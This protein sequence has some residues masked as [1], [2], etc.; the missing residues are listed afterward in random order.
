MNTMELIQTRKSVRTFD[1]RPLTEEDRKALEDYAKTITN[2]YEI[3]VSFV[4]LDAEEHGLSSPV[5]NGEHLYVA[6]KVPKMPHC[7][8]AF[9]YS[10]CH[11]MSVTEGEFS[12]SDPGI[13]TGENIE[14]IATVTVD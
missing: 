1:G 9:G 10:F 12:I 2:P 13:M 4:F 7:E 6:G 8:E 14:Y 3:P 11:F 5:I